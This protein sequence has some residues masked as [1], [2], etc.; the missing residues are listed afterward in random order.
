MKTYLRYPS[1]TDCP[2]Y[3]LHDGNTVMNKGGIRLHPFDRC[4]TA[5]KRAHKFRKNEAKRKIPAWCP[6]RKSPCELRIYG[7]VSSEAWFAH[8]LFARKDRR[9]HSPIPSRYGLRYEGSTELAP[10]EFWKECCKGSLLPAL[11]TTVKLYEVVEIDD[12][13]MPVC[14]YRAE[15]GYRI[16]PLFKTADARKRAAM[17]EE[18]QNEKYS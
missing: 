17:R 5:L 7:F 14:F 1:C 2:N 18:S 8:V 11:P 4:C 13:L 16:E 12:G 15:G 10:Q 9:L 3:F 6:K